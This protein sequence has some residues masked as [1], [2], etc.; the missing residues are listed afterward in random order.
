MKCFSRK[1][2]SI[3]G[4]THLLLGLL[5]KTK[6]G[7]RRLPSFFISENILELPTTT[8]DHFNLAYHE[9]LW[10][11]LSVCLNK[12]QGKRVFLFVIIVLY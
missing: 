7:Q 2:G 12:I 6:N 3:Y 11:F 10:F 4:I 5:R 8:S 1:K 9:T